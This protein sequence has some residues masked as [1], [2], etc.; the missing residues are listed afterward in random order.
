MYSSRGPCNA[1]E[2]HISPGGP[3]IA[4]KAHV[5]LWKGMYICGGQ[6]IAVEGY[7]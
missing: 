5:W 4:A 1:L 6:C 7:V 2:G 3:C